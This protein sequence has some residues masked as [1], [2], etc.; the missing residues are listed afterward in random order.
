MKQEILNIMMA[1]TTICCPVA[2]LVLM[3]NSY[4]QL[5]V[6]DK[7]QGF[8]RNPFAFYL[9]IQWAFSGSIQ[10][11]PI[12]TENDIQRACSVL[13]AKNAEEIKIT[14]IVDTYDTEGMA[15]P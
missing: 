5:T 2:L 1:F 13:R 4:Y 7:L 9:P 14:S 10:T 8:I 3:N 15:K 11:L 12:E 6:L